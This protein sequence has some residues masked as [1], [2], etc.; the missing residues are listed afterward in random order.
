MQMSFAKGRKNRAYGRVY[1]T[2][3]MHLNFEFKAKTNELQLLETRLQSLDPRFEGLD[4]QTDTYFHVPHGRLKLREGPIENALI[5]YNRINSAGAK[6]SDVILYRHNQ[7]PQLKE[8]LIASLGVKVVVSKKR[9]IYFI[10]NVKFHFDE[11]ADLGSFI[12]V[13]AIDMS[14]DIG[15]NR[16]KEQCEYFAAFF[17]VREEDYIADSYSDL[18]LYKREGND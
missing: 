6:R 15:L 3:P 14:G 16:L 5:H 2:L 10:G 12:E 18:L 11:V 13:E 9:K 7:D 1:F 17:G 8:A 4:E